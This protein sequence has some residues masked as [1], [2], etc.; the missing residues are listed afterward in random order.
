MKRIYRFAPVGVLCLFS[1][2]SLA[3]AGDVTVNCGSEN[4]ISKAL[5]ALNPSVPKTITVSG[6]CNENVSIQ[7]FTRLTLVGKSGASINDASG[8]TAFVVD[9]EDST[10]KLQGLAING[11]TVGVFCGNFSVCRFGGNTIQNAS[12]PGVQVVQSRATFDT[13]TIQNNGVG[14]T[15][16]ESSSVRS[17]GGL[18][19]QQNNGSGVIADT[20]GSFVAVSTTIQNN[21][22]PGIETVV[23]AS[24]TLL[25]NTISGNQAYGVTVLGRSEAHFFQNNV[26]TGNSSGGVAVRDVSHALFE[27]GNTIT[28][29]TANGG[30]DVACL[31]QFPTTRGALTNI[32]GGTTNCVEP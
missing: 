8:G 15:S 27:V 23:G 24:L 19:V 3:W 29:N 26:I 14:L 5:A 4:T 17:N 6:Q 9:I 32:G 31:Q 18:M 30:L 28:G 21:A 16:L 20:D 22:G 1:F 13:G 25:G 12:G 7:S 2:S 11:G 10:V